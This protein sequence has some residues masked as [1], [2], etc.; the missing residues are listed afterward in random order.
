[1]N[2]R[3]RAA[4]AA[5]L[6]AEVH[7]VAPVS[8]GDINQAYAV[9]LDD[10]RRVFV[11]ANPGADPRMF[12][13]EARGLAWLGEASAVR[14]P[15]VLAA[16]ADVLV[17]EL[18]ESGRRVRDFDRRL[19]RGLAELHRAAAPCFGLDHDNFLATLE[20][21]NRPLDSWP[22]FY[23]SRRLEPLVARA[24][25]GGH[26]PARWI[27]RFDDL[28]ARM[29]EL[30]GPP[31]PPARLHG[32]LWSGNVHADGDGL[33][34]LIDPA[35]YGGHREVDLAMLRLFGSPGDDFFAAYDE[36][37]PRAP[38][39]DERVALYQLYPLLAHV[40]LFG[41]SYSGAVERALSTYE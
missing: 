37:L 9:T 23:A 19:G 34:V 30:S 40:N 25:D 14:V 22:A 21:D 3:V 41:A 33:P 5:A 8:G 27:R 20:Q 11:K 39:A 17:L 7:Q 32:D 6:G 18:I 12:P 4:V 24:I 26:A 35:V 28:F 16:T 2:P 29:A 31:E 1:M 15:R 36:V 38:G 13:C 10:R